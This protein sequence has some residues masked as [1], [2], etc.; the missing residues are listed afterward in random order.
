MVKIVLRLSQSRVDNVGYVITAQGNI[1]RS[2]SHH[3]YYGRQQTRSIVALDAEK[4]TLHVSF[5]QTDVGIHGRK[6]ISFRYED[7]WYCINFVDF[8]GL[9]ECLSRPKM[10]YWSFTHWLI[11]MTQSSEKFLLV[12][13]VNLVMTTLKSVWAWYCRST[14]TDNAL[15]I[16]SFQPCGVCFFSTPLFFYSC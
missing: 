13:L 6:C 3:L 5:I 2:S 1:L 15:Y 9:I 7:S 10:L 14:Q 8:G 11:N 12:S 16:M 4:P